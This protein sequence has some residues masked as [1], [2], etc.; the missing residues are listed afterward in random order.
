MKE[1]YGLDGAQFDH[2]CSECE[3]EVAKLVGRLRRQGFPERDIEDAKQ[4]AF[5][6]VWEIVAKDVVEIKNPKTRSRLINCEAE[7][8]RYFSKVVCNI[9]A[10][11]WR[12]YKKEEDTLTKLYEREIALLPR[13]EVSEGDRH[14]VELVAEINNN[15]GRHPL[16]YSELKSFWSN[17]PDSNHE[18]YRRIIRFRYIDRLS[19][20]GTMQQLAHAINEIWPD[21][22]FDR[23]CVRATRLFTSRYVEKLIEKANNL[24][25]YKPPHTLGTF[26]DSMSNVPEDTRRCAEEIYVKVRCMYDVKE[27]KDTKNEADRLMNRAVFLLTELIFDR[28]DFAPS[29]KTEQTLT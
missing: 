23:E 12:I 21:A 20:M 7:R 11:L 9:C 27:S 25:I 26:L 16:E 19:R 17:I 8:F 6:V 28:V 4:E 1:Q 10:A 13:V 15:K 3:S 29:K 18:P 22:K 5:I 2:W 14:F 24:Q